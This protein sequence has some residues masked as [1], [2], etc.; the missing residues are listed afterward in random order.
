MARLQIQQVFKL[1]E[2][3]QA[4]L[5]G[6]VQDIEKR[7]R[8]VLEGQVRKIRLGL[9]EDFKEIPS[10]V[11]QGDGRIDIEPDGFCLERP[12]S[13]SSLL[14]RVAIEQRG[15]RRFANTAN[16]CQDKGGYIRFNQPG[17]DF[18]HSFLTLLDGTWICRRRNAPDT[19]ID[20]LLKRPRLR[21]VHV[22]GRGNMYDTLR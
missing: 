7:H 2:N 9:S 11:G 10:K 12:I 19:T 5:L 14:F 1:V 3:H 13:R 18:S 4:R 22:N 15:Q 20:S 21:R 17:K 6:R 8:L 16:A